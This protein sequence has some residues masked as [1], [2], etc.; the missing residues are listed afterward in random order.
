MVENQ[1]ENF[2]RLNGGNN[3]TSDNSD[4]I[5]STVGFAI[6]AWGRKLYL[7]SREL[8]GNATT[9][10][11]QWW[12]RNRNTKGWH[13]ITDA[14]SADLM[15]EPSQELLVSLECGSFDMVY[16]VVSGSTGSYEVE[17]LVT[18]S[19]RYESAAAGSGNSSGSS[20]P[21]RYYSYPVN[22]Q[23]KIWAPAFYLDFEDSSVLDRSGYGNDGVLEGTTPPTFSSSQKVLGSHGLQITPQNPPGSRKN[24][25]ERSAGSTLWRRCSMEFFLLGKDCQYKQRDLAAGSLEFWIHLVGKRLRSPDQLVRLPGVGPLRC[26]KRSPCQRS[27]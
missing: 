16:P 25:R 20:S 11:V 13:K 9:V 4:P 22:P 27:Q 14:V 15:A 2:K 17:H 26:G 7:E 19:D 21:L 18:F 8:L 12:G 24:R 10:P 3:Q 6:P 1:T 23:S 5:A